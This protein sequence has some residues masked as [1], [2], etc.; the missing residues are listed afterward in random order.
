MIQMN[1]DSFANTAI[2]KHCF[3]CSSKIEQ[4]E[5]CSHQSNYFIHR[6]NILDLE[7]E[8]HPLSCGMGI[9]IKGWLRYEHAS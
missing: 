9:K 5:H 7:A 2:Q 3:L 6:N 1:D 8:I 4:V